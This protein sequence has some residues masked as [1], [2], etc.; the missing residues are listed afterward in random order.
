MLVADTDSVVDRLLGFTAAG[1][2]AVATTCL[3]FCISKMFL[4]RGLTGALEL[5]TDMLAGNDIVPQHDDNNCESIVL[6]LG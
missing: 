5:M 6:V 3:S 2:F 1:C 4:C